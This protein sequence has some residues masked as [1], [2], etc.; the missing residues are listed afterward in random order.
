MVVALADAEGVITEF[1][2]VRGE[3]E[4]CGKR[5][6]GIRRPSFVFFRLPQRRDE[7]PHTAP[8]APSRTYPLSRGVGVVI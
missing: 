4:Q 1:L 2:S 8:P 5:C 6:A 3:S 7:N